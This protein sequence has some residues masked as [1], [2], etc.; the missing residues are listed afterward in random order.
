MVET[1][2]TLVA[3]TGAPE[4]LVEFRLQQ[5]APLPVSK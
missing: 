4:T 5:P 2:E 1:E 3:R